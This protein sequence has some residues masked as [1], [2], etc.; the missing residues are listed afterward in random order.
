ML[1]A[2]LRARAGLSEG[3]ALAL[4]ETPEGL[5]LLTR[6]QLKRRVREHLADLQLVDELL[7]ERRA[8]VAEQDS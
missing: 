2:E 5:V 1:P 4:I 3:T 7:A 6:A 8:E